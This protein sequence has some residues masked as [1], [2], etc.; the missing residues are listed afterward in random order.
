[1]MTTARQARDATDGMSGFLCD[2][3]FELSPAVAGRIATMATLA[4][5]GQTLPAVAGRLERGASLARGVRVT[6][7]ASSSAASDSG[8]GCDAGRRRARSVLGT[9]PCHGVVRGNHRLTFAR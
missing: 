1:M 5:S 2:L 9:Y 7:I 6:S 3:T 8:S 4:R